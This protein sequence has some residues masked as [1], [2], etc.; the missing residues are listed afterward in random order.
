MSKKIYFETTTLSQ[1]D[2]ENGTIFGI[3]VISTPEA[4]GH[5][6]KIDTKSIFIIVDTL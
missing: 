6:L 4:K 3:S 1:I 2:K 5:N